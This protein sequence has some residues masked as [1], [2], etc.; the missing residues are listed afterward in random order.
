[1]VLFSLFGVMLTAPPGLLV[2]EAG[3]VESSAVAA[4]CW[5]LAV[6]YIVLAAPFLFHWAAVTLGRAVGLREG[7]GRGDDPAEPAAAP[8]RGRM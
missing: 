2:R 8:D 3:S 5:A 6:G 4:L 1:M 7:T